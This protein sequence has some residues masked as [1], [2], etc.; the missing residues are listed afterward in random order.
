MIM[1]LQFLGLRTESPGDFK[2]VDEQGYIRIF[3][4]YKKWIP[5]F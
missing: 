5:V 2:A 1:S 4:I 3:L